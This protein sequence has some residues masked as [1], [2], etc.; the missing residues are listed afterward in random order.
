MDYTLRMCANGIYIY[1]YTDTLAY[2]NV[3][4]FM[5]IYACICIHIDLLD[6][7]EHLPKSPCISFSLTQYTH[8]QIMFYSFLFGEMYSKL[9]LL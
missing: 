2:V 9:N 7:V 6:C 4:L 1:E 3:Y 8:I 5:H